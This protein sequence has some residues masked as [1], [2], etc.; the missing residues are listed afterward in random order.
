MMKRTGYCGSVACPTHPTGILFNILASVG[1]PARV[2]GHAVTISEGHAQCAT[3]K[4]AA[5]EVT[6]RQAT[7]GC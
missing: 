3:A 1:V 5:R 7:T 2:V 6:P 4:Q